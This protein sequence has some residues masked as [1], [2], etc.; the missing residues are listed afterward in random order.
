MTTDQRID[1]MEA[2]KAPLEKVGISA[3]TAVGLAARTAA[4]REWNRSHDPAQCAEATREALADGDLLDLMADAGL[5]SWLSG[6][7]RVFLDVPEL[8]DT[9][10]LEL[11]GGAKAGAY[12]NAIR[13]LRDRVK[14]VDDAT[15]DRVKAAFR[16]PADKEIAKLGKEVAARVFSALTEAV[17]TGRS[18]RQGVAILRQ[19][20]TDA[21][22]VPGKDHALATLFR[23]QVQTAY[24]AGRFD[25]WK[26]DAVWPLI[27]GFR[28][29]TVGD[30][31][32]RPAHVKMNGVQRPKDDPIWD[33]WTPPAGYNCRCALLEILWP[34][35]GSAEPK[36]TPT[37]KDAAPDE[38]FDFNP[39]DL[40]AGVDKSGPVPS[41]R[42]GKRRKG[43]GPAPGR[44]TEP[45][46]T[47]VYTPDQLTRL[48]DMAAAVDDLTERMGPKGLVSVRSE[49]ADTETVRTHVAHLSAVPP[50]TM[51]RLGNAGVQ[52]AVDN[53]PVGVA[54]PPLRGV[55][56]DGL[57]GGTW[58]DVPAAWLARSSTAY[59]GGG[60]EHL[61]TS[62]ALNTLGRA[63]ES[64]LT[65]AELS[66]A[67]TIH[68][69]TFA[70]LSPNLQ[71]S[72]PGS[73]RGTQELVAEGFAVF[74]LLGAEVARQLFGV[75][76]TE[77]LTA[78]LFTTL[79]VAGVG[80][81]D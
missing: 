33:V 39:L 30:D 47:R 15:A 48:A 6:W 22:L 67:Q 61:S 58:N 68:A 66:A 10:P 3:A 17:R 51:A 60:A 56:P 64:T 18:E 26:D 31:R 75:E 38:G 70:N 41:L 19:A 62:L 24:S 43:T 37:P 4:I 53:R 13:F 32:V 73:I 76:F 7:R 79:E 49:A 80:K 1:R 69:G 5:A 46:P 14:T 21:G 81:A 55:V 35:D 77:W 44:I 28:Y 57:T 20:M 8:G 16:V 45:S 29:V 27:W 54:L 11:A 36:A 9:A 52:I 59:V 65:T 71:Q 50:E 25:A 42:T 63:L 40:L 74:V 78:V 12:G 34:R 2:D 72:G 23:T